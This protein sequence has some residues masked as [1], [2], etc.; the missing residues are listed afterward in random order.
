MNDLSAHRVIHNVRSF[1]RFCAESAAT[2]LSIRADAACAPVGLV[3]LSALLLFTSRFVLLCQRCRE[4]RQGTAA[5]EAVFVSIYWFLGELCGA[6]GAAL[7]QQLDIQI[8][9]GVLAVAVDFVNVFSIFLM[10]YLCWGSPA[11][12]RL[13]VI[14]R[15]RRQH[16]L[17]VCLLMGLG[18]YITYS[19][20]NI[21]AHKPFAGRKL[22][23][24]FLQD[25]TE[26]LGY[27]LGLI[28]FTIA[29]TSRFPAINHACRREKMTWAAGVS[30]VLCS[31]AGLLYTSALL[32]S[33]PRV[34]GL[35]LKAA[36][37]LLSALCSATL[38][39]LVSCLWAQIWG[40][41]FPKSNAKTLKTSEIGH[42][43]DVSV[44][45]AGNVCLKELILSAR[46]NLKGRPP[47]MRSMRL[48]QVDSLSSSC[49][50]YDSSSFSSDLEW[51]FEEAM[52]TCR[53]EPP[54]RREKE[55]E[56]LQDW[57][58]NPPPFGTC[59]CSVSDFTE[60]SLFP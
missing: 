36:P 12:R 47:T 56:F 33:D 26:A 46:D 23:H 60:M 4:T 6:M 39:L 7:S 13:R 1:Y 22:L 3:A 18:G 40:F 41:S 8:V 52:S 24:A 53:S 14:R 29:C 59:T 55:D 5:G 38:D 27:T 17:G 15:R 21:P 34:P 28:S 20:S 25:N 2:C 16:L 19:N 32:L 58:K 57:P 43:M 54:Q 44:Q 49:S 35:L 42:Y 11:D 51:D 10:L 31:L 50:S 30:A 48:V 45:P 37:W 9:F